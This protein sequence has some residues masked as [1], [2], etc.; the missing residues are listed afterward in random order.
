MQ[1]ITVFYLL[2]ASIVF[3]R[4]LLIKADVK[5]QSSLIGEKADSVNFCLSLIL[6]FFFVFVVSGR[7]FYHTGDTQTYLTLYRNV[8]LY[9]FS[10]IGEYFRVEYGFLV[11]TK[12]INFFGFSERGYLV[13][14]SL[15]QAALWLICLNRYL[16]SAKV[17]LALFFF[18]SFFVSYNAGANVLRQGISI[19]IAFIAGSFFIKRNYL[20]SLAIF[21]IATIFHTTSLIVL[22]SFIVSVRC[23][24]IRY[25]FLMF[26]L[27]TLLSYL[28]LFSGFITMVPGLSDSYSHILNATEK[29]DVGFR[30]GFWVFTTIPLVLYFF[31]TK[32]GKEDNDLL[33]KIYLT[34]SSIF[35]IA[36]AIPYSD[37]F[38]LYAWLFMI[39]LV[40]NS[41]GS[42]RVSIFNDY[43]LFLIV[44]ALL[45]AGMFLFFPLMQ[46]T[47][48]FSE[49]F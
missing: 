43:K 33:F 42:Y 38:G 44:V 26:L 23:I 30:Y 45:G 10:E 17:L 3:A 47:Y 32:A 7:S 18:I 27:L 12:L 28:N 36:F 4:F 21:Y 49:I 14:V 39:V 5:Q 46:L 11:L 9:S 22:L 15:I 19:P 40:P 41:L 1:Y 25:Y 48:K 8:G 16:S 13:V 6:A 34:F 37:R 24:A 31:L 20:T 2:I 29:Y 35:T